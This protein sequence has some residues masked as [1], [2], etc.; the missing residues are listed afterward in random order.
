MSALQRPGTIE[1]IAGSRSTELALTYVAAMAGTPLAALLPILTKS[2][3]SERQRLRVEEALKSI[4]QVLE[5]HERNLH[6]LTDAQYK[7]VNEAILALLHTTSAEKFR[8]LRQVVQNSLHQQ[9]MRPQEAVVL[10][11]I[12]RDISV[13]E[14]AFVARNF[15]FSRVWLTTANN[16]D[17]GKS[18][19][20]DPNSPEASIVGGLVSLGLLFSASSDYAGLGMLNWSPISAKLMAILREPAP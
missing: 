2:L 18:K 5:T 17:G 9:D 19:I 10:S 1:R 16:E 4:Q 3:A 13:E 14:I 8:Y 11:R 15:G 20:V 7:L 6:D 12:V